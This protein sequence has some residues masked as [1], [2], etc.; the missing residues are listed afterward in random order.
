[1]TV[2]GPLPSPQVPR[3][4]IDE[5]DP[6]TITGVHRALNETLSQKMRGEK[7]FNLVVALIALV[8]SLG[9][10]IGGYTHIINE[11]RAQADA[12]V[13]PVDQKLTRLE[14]VVEQHLASD[15]AYK[16]RQEDQAYRA[17]IE[18]RELQKVVLTG[19]SSPLLNEPPPPPRDA[20][21]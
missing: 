9:T 2:P 4:D 21:R 20:G 12:G 17:A 6:T 11:A 3:D 1:M 10:L 14:Q 15:A 13:Q 16:I 18:M 5:N 7:I 19:R 8:I